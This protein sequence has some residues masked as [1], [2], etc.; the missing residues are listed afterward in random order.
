MSKDS[1]TTTEEI[2]VK[3]NADAQLKLDVAH[4]ILQR[5]DKFAE[6]FLKAATS[7]SSIKE[8]IRKEIEESL[9]LDPKSRTA[10]KVLMKEHFKDDWK[11]FMFSTGGKIAFGIWSIALIFLTAWVSHVWGK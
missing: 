7:Q 6:I 5:P 4:D 11:A 10:L 9:T 2:D 1:K 8:H 3:F